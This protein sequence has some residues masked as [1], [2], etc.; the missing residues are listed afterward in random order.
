MSSNAE[1]LLAAHDATKKAL[2][3]I[4]ANGMARPVF[5]T[6]P[7]VAHLRGALAL[8]E[9]VDALNLYAQNDD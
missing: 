7:A 8:L 2:A 1:L 4:P 5:N 3:E 9:A 6:R